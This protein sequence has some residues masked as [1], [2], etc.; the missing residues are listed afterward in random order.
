MKSEQPITNVGARRAVPQHDNAGFTL[1]EIMIALA[2][3]GLTITVI[4]N[5]VN[6]HANILYENTITTKT[7]QL[8][9]EKMADFE[10]TTTPS[11]GVLEALKGYTFENSATNIEGSNIVMLKTVVTGNGKEVVLKRLIIKG[12]EG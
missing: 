2:I 7:Y 12:Y 3:I 11:S 9:K 6:F 4:L 1:L 10:K 8:A 5:S